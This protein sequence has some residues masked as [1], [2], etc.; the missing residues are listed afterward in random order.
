MQ[1]SQAGSLVPPAADM[2]GFSA[3]VQKITLP[4]EMQ[5]DQFKKKRIRRSPR[6]RGKT[7]NGVGGTW[8]YLK[9]FP[10]DGKRSAG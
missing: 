4:E 9:T 3:M 10:I 6:G 2:A 1:T 5:M 8:A 7:M